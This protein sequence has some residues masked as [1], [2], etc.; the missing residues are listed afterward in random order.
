M[1]RWPELPKPPGRYFT[2]AQAC[3]CPQWRFRPQQRPCKHV[4]RLREAE[5]LDRGHGSQVGH[6]GARMSL[7]NCQH[8]KRSSS[9]E[10]FGDLDS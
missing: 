9:D 10:V 7:V 3:S 2:T 6:D 5:G 4:R 8:A 1:M